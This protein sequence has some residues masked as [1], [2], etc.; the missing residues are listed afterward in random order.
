L[1]KGIEHARSL[2]LIFISKK[3]NI[4]DLN[5][6]NQICFFQ[7]KG[8]SDNIA[9]LATCAVEK[10]E[11]NLIELRKLLVSLLSEATLLGLKEE[12]LSSFLTEEEYLAYHP[13]KKRKRKHDPQNKKVPFISSVSVSEILLLFLLLFT[14]VFFFLEGVRRVSVSCVW[15]HRN[16]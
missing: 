8:T 5:R 9:K 12:I 4:L 16:E 11:Q 14:L 10:N 7:I 15:R 2:F 1:V 13:G 6:F 3:T